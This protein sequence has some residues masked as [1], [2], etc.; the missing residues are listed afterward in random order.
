VRACVHFVRFR[1]EEYHSAV[2]VFG[3]PDFVHIQWD[4]FARE[5]IA[6][7]DT[8]V[9]ARGSDADPVAARGGP[10]RH[11]RGLDAAVRGID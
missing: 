5:L 11:E 1:G 10:C 9:F 8:V 2:R 6:P 4:R 7:G 3:L